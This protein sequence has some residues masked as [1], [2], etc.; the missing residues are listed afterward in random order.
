MRMRTIL[1][2]S[3]QTNLRQH[4]CAVACLL[5]ISGCATESLEWQRRTKNDF[6]A[7]VDMVITRLGNVLDEKR[8]LQYGPWS[9]MS[10]K[11]GPYATY[12]CPEGGVCEINIS[13]LQCEHATRG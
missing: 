9:V 11:G 12:Q 5:L 7:R 8:G 6:P 13:N 4:C 3:S 1:E 2:L 10:G